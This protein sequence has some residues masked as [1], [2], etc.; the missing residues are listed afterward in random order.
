MKLIIIVFCFG[1]ML[2]LSATV[3]NIPAD[4]STIQQGLDAVA[5]FD[6]V[7]VEAGTYYENITWPDTD[8]IKLIGSGL[9]NCILD[10]SSISS[11]IRFE[12]QAMSFDE[13]TLIAG[14]T[15]QNGYAHGVQQYRHGGGLFLM[16]ASI[17]LR[18]LVINNNSAIY[19]GGLMCFN[20]SHANLEN[21]VITNNIAEENGG[22]LRCKYTSHVVLTNSV[23]SNNESTFGYGGGIAVGDVSEP[24]ISYTLIS[25]NTA[26]YGGGV[27]FEK[28]DCDLINCTIVNNSADI[29]GGGV[30]CYAPSNIIK[31]SILWDNSPDQ[32]FYNSEVTYTD[33]QEGWNGT[34]NI[35]LNPL[36]MD[37]SNGN[38][39][40]TANSPCID[41]GNP[42]SSYDPDNTIADM[43]CFY[44]DQLVGINN[45]QCSIIDFQLS[46]YPNPFNPTTLILFSIPEDSNINLSV[47]NMRGQKINTLTNDDYTKGSHSVT[48]NGEDE[49]GKQVGSG[50]YFYKL[51][52]NGKTELVKKCMLLK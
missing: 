32:L 47:Y 40:L 19:G 23:I 11:V 45:N 35:D 38:Y 27:Y 28:G 9:D 44:F 37:A 26:V 42:V 49:S 31:N 34:G 36:F 14:F 22:G 20:Y 29:E 48:W 25:D 41:S 43:G 39:H 16:N 46:N 33:I 51:N 15:I 6:T 8:G 7:M 2:A 50:I 24:Y 1:F 12:S 30:H 5:S 4:Y 52:V 21:V 10:G 17:S 18:D 3:I 13:S